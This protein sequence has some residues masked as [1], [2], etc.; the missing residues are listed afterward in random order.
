MASCID[1]VQSGSSWPE[2][3]AGSTWPS[4][5]SLCNSILFAHVKC[6]LQCSEML[7]NNY[8][9]AIL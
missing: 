3:S 5:L 7:L 2:K 4:Q 9:I 8:E 6:S 1:V